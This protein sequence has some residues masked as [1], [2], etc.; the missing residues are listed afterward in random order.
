MEITFDNIT[1]KDELDNITFTVDNSNINGIYNYENI[2]KILLNPESIDKGKVLIDNHIYRKYNPSFIA[3]I[4]KEKEFYTS[5]VIDEILFYAKVRGY[6]NKNI[7]QEINSLLDEL[8]LDKDILNR[9]TPSL[10]TTEKYFIKLIANLIYKP[11]IIVFKDIMNGLDLNNKKLLKKVINRLQEQGTLIIIASMD[12]NILYELTRKLIIIEK[13]D[14]IIGNTDE[15]YQQVEMLL[16]KNVDIPY[17][18]LLTYKAKKEK[19]INLFYRKDVR[20]V[21]KDVYKSV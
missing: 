21:I 20:D 12:S 14:V 19:N 18:S 8:N 4:D 11:K 13:N 16:T 5:R 3:V 17:F 7:K 2:T 10:S 6:K 9:I 1:Y 15:I